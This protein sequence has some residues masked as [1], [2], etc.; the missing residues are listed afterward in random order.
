MYVIW[1]VKYKWFHKSCTRNYNEHVGLVSTQ[2]PAVLISARTKLPHGIENVSVHSRPLALGTERIPL[3]NHA[4]ISSLYQYRPIFV[5]CS[6]V[7][8]PYILHGSVRKSMSHIIIII[9]ITTIHC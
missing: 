1:A 8:V 9:V 2:R 7:I 3:R 5:V 6:A 4:S